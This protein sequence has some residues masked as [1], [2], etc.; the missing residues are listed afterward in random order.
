MKIFWSTIL[1]VV[2]LSISAQDFEDL[3]FGTDSTLDVVTWNIEWFPKNGQTTIEYVA[4]IIQAIDADIY[5]LQEIGDVNDLLNM[6]DAINGYDALVTGTWDTALAYLIKSSTISVDDD[7]SIYEAYSRE[8]PREPYVL[9]FHYLGIPYALINNHLKCCGDGTIDDD[10][11]W[12]EET[13]R[14]DACIL[15][16]EFMDDEYDGNRAMMVGD[17]N[18]IL[19]DNEEDNVFLPFLNNSDYLFADQYISQGSDDEWSFP[20]WPSHLDHLLLTDEVV[21]DWQATDEHTETIHVEDHMGG[22][23]YYD[24]NVSDHRPVGVRL[25]P[26]PSS[27][28]ISESHPTTL[29]LFPNPSSG[30]I[31]FRNIKSES[32]IR[33]YNSL[34]KLV[35]EGCTDGPNNS[36]YLDVIPG[37]YLVIVEHCSSTM[38][39]LFIIE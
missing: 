23:W 5:A 32:T 19:T 9:E 3:S 13:R 18:D 6:T 28:H 21:V 31:T 25:F 39:N 14:R 37:I 12:D 15:L 26:D 35:W 30:E 38:K 22:W 8:F 2:G 7:F 33:I 27:V 1:C 16:Q 4:E 34:G 29:E 17:L 11:L 36:I 20:N 24:N 10:D